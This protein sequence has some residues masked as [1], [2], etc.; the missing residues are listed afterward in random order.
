MTE[1]E[2]V[3]RSFFETLSSGDLDRLAAYIDGDSTWTVCATGIPG[4]GTHRGKAIIDEFLQPVRGL[5]EP[6]EPKVEITN[7]VSDGRWV[8]CEGIGRGRFRTGTEYRNT[9]SY[10]LEVEGRI[11]RTMREYMDS[12]Y[13]ASLT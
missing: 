5:F 6:G 7:L 3:V 10:W 4:A 1:A 2:S 12:A 11:V 8:A 13:V 9:Y